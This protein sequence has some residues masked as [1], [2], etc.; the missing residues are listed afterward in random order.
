MIFEDNGIKVSDTSKYQVIMYDEKHNLLPPNKQKHI[1]YEK[2]KTYFSATI[3]KC[4][5]W[6]YKDPAFYI[7]WRNAK[8][9]GIPRSSYWFC[10][11]RAKGKAQAQLYW[12]YI[13]NDIGEGFLAADFEFGSWRDWKELYNFMEELQQ[14][15]GLPNHKIVVYTGYYYFMEYYPKK[16]SEQEWFAKYP[17]WIAA[18]TSGDP[19]YVKIPPL[20]KKA[21]LWQNGTPVIGYKTG[22]WSKEIDHNIVNGGQEE[23]EYFFNSGKPVVVT[24]TPD[25]IFRRMIVERANGSKI[26]YTENVRL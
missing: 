15:S 4:G 3:L 20:W 26:V 6:N 5:Q 18:Y 10:D 8:A 7:G 23:F 9:A 24:P 12:S 21:F 25:K 2:M 1:D 13:K 19:K 16:A 14:L 11:Y 17:L 22:V